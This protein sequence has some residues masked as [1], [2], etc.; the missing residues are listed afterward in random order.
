ML[1][2]SSS[3]PTAF[4]KNNSVDRPGAGTP[5]AAKQLDAQEMVNSKKI[6]IHFIILTSML[7]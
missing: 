4:G 5:S 7:L 1:K 2:S 6:V 3:S